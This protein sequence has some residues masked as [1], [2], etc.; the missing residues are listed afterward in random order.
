MDRVTTT[1]E[2]T[3]NRTDR[4]EDLAYTELINAVKDAQRLLIDTEAWAVAWHNG[5]GATP[6][7]NVAGLYSAGPLTDVMQRA[8]AYRAAA[9]AKAEQPTPASVFIA[10]RYEPEP[11]TRVTLGIE[12]ATRL[13]VF[14]SEDDAWTAAAEDGAERWDQRDWLSMD[15]ARWDVESVSVLG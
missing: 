12:A 5:E 7:F 2:Q 13:G 8:Q 4:T 11:D 15:D 9:E 3:M 6:P 10:T 14:T 1:K